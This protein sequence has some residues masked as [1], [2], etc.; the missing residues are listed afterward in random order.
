M[1]EI[2]FSNSL[3]GTLMC[4]KERRDGG[5]SVVSV[6]ACGE[7]GTPM[8]EEEM[9][10][11]HQKVQAEHEKAQAEMIPLGGKSWQVFAFSF[12]LSRGDISEDFPDELRL[13]SQ[14]ELCGTSRENVNDI[15]DMA[16]H[17]VK[18]IKDGQMQWES[19]LTFLEQDE[20]L[21][22]W[23]NPRNPDDV[24][25]LYW[26]LW[27]LKKS[28]LSP[29]LWRMALPEYF[30]EPNG[31]IVVCRGWPE[32]VPEK[33]G[34]Y[35]YLQ[36]EVSVVFSTMAYCAWEKLREENAALRAMVNG[37]ICSVPEDFY[38]GIIRMELEKQPEQFKEPS[39][40]ADLLMKTCL[41]AMGDEFIHR[42]LM[43]LVN[44]GILSVVT[45]SEDGSYRG[46]ILRKNK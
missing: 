18:Q 10:A 8:T 37:T 9:E 17:L 38:D 32:I 5:R 44:D 42:R 16:Y 25:G 36:Q 29:K 7:N 14:M 15:K 24:C 6:I 20:E 26:F 11:Y 2:C 27:L 33:L 23:Y 1:L 28:N 46:Q 31:N 43:K 35:L 40:I 22:I 3:R 13:N 19:L 34:H 21:R 4:A 30:T 39:F 45:A 12:G 41:G